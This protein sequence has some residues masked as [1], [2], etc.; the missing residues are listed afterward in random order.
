M[1]SD[2]CSPFFAD[3]HFSRES[4]AKLMKELSRVLKTEGKQQ[5]SDD[6]IGKAHDTRT[7]GTSSN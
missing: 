6:W 4:L 1:Q 7:M 5:E 2:D 3:S